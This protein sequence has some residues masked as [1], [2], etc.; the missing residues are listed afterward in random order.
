MK[1]YLIFLPFL[2]ILFV[3]CQKIQDGL[4]FSFF[5][6]NGAPT[7]SIV[8]NKEAIY[9][10]QTAVGLTNTGQQTLTCS[11][12]T[13]KT[14]PSAWMNGFTSGCDTTIQRNGA[15]QVCSPFVSATVTPGQ[16][17]AFS[18]ALV[19]TNQFESTTATTFTIY[20]NCQY[21]YGG[22][23]YTIPKSFSKTILVKPDPYADFSIDVSM[24]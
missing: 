12:D 9:Y 21:T 4:G 16:R 5:G 20:I 3:G 14:V 11:I 22:Q 6:I 23:V 13:S 17:L 10:M 18:S 19:R 8:D 24:G 15:N 7:K 2:L 1:K